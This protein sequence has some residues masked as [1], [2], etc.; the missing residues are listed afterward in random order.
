MPQRRA[1]LMPG[2]AGDED[3]LVPI[4][5]CRHVGFTALRLPR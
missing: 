3:H 5:I 1:A 2:R 4:L